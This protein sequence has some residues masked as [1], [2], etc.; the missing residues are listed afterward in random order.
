MIVLVT[1]ALEGIFAGLI[2]VMSY[3]Y[4]NSNLD[5]KRVVKSFES[6]EGSDMWY[7]KPTYSTSFVISIALI[8][9]I[10]I[11]YDLKR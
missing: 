9:L 4:F 2:V 6:N 5:S 7:D 3:I 11:F 8:V 10:V 1:E